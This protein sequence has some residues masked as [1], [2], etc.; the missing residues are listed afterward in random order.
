MKLPPLRAIQCF[1]SVARFNSFS[2]A[3]IA[4]HVTQSAVSHQVRLLE[5]YLGETLFVRQGRRLSLTPIGERYYE[6]VSHSLQNIAQASY[7]IREGES[8]KIRIAMYS[9]LAVKW[10]VPRLENLRQQHPE[11]DLTLSMVAD[12]PEF[13]DQVA[14]C[15]ITANPPKKNYVS[16]FLYKE[17]LYPFCSQK[18]WQRIEDK[19]L[20]E[21]LWDQQLLSVSSI[22]KDD[23]EA[24]DWAKWCELGGFSLPKDV[25][26]SQF[27]HMVLA[28]EAVKYHQGIAFLNDYFLNDQDLQQNLVRIPM[29]DLP[30]GDNMYFVYK[31]SRA[32]QFEI[33]TLGHWLKQ[34]CFDYE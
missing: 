12:E 18:V 4:L 7:Q 3:A 21:A 34:Q 32:K 20:P 19:P 8:G 29:H 5:E 26:I 16:D 1:E 31:N 11:I 24:K 14:D 33:R 6:E 2:Q 28:A 22:F 27:S 10:L 25:K 13:S 9:S 30:T 15:F 23:G 17:Q